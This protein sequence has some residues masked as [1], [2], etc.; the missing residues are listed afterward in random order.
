MIDRPGGQDRW[1]PLFDRML[2]GVPPADIITLH[3]DSDDTTAYTSAN[4]RILDEARM[5]ADESGSDVM[6]IIAWDAK[7]RGADDQTVQFAQSA[8][9]RGMPV[10][11]IATR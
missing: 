11:E 9:E 5:L 4:G 8:R 3:E 6:A 7:P 10:H 1:G 2:A